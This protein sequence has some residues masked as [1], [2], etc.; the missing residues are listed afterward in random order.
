MCKNFATRK[1]LSYEKLY[2]AKLATRSSSEEYYDEKRRVSRHTGERR[3]T[4]TGNSRFLNREEILQKPGHY[5][6][7]R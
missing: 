7:V 3:E 6:L 1:R 5:R 2:Q 4:T